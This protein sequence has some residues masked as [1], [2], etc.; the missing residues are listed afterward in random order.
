MA[1]LRW[2]QRRA[3]RLVQVQVLGASLS[4]GLPLGPRLASPP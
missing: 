3:R 1:T 4:L 2:K